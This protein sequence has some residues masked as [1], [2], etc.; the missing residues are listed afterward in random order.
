MLAASVLTGEVM[1][2][3]GFYL[4]SGLVTGTEGS[5]SS[6]IHQMSYNFL[7]CL[8]EASWVLICFQLTAMSRNKS[9]SGCKC[10][11]W[12]A[13]KLFNAISKK[14][15]LVAAAIFFSTKSKAEN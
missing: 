10:A 6:R 13:S 8:Q 12:E 1:A 4:T 15:Q 2:E 7:L 11:L 9:M 3:N 5:T 14:L